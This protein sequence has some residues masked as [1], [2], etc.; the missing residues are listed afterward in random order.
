MKE[1]LISQKPEIVEKI[2]SGRCAIIVTKQRPKIEPPFKCYVY[3]TSVKKMTLSKY[4][5]IHKKT[6]GEIDDMSGR[7]V[8]EFICNRIEDFSQWNDY[9]SLLRHITL[10]TDIKD[11]P[12]WDYY[13][14][15]K[16]SGYGWNISALTRYDIPKEV[17]DFTSP[18]VCKK[19]QYQDDPFFSG[20]FCTGEEEDCPYF[21]CP[22][23]GGEYDD[24]EDYAYCL[25][26]G[27]E[28]L[29]SIK[30]WCYVEEIK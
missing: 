12:I 4:V 5:E 19:A 20:W 11:Y 25:S 2:A 24:Y 18:T 13:L 26:K 27:K 9:P 14:K 15:G 22:S 1:I 29:K 16:K 28:P 23:C 10:N 8:G 30:H 6:N 17:E 3:C 21:D 7:V